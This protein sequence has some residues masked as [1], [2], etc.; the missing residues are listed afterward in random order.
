MRYRVISL[1]TRTGSGATLSSVTPS[2]RRWPIQSSWEGNAETSRAGERVTSAILQGNN[3]ASGLNTHALF[4]DAT[5]VRTKLPT[6]ERNRKGWAIGLLEPQRGTLIPPV[7]GQ[8]GVGHQLVGGEA[9]RLLSREDRGDNVRGEKS[10]SNKARCIGRRDLLLM[11]D[12]L[13]RWTVRLEHSLGDL[14]T[15]HE[16]SDQGRIRWRG[17]RDA[18]DDELHLLAGPLQARGNAEPDQGFFRAVGARAR[19]PMPFDNPLAGAVVQKPTDQPRQADL[20][21]DAIRTNLRPDEDGAR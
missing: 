19:R 13:D 9:G 12:V 10:Q 2:A 14:L 1:A 21:V 11:R 8:T 4:A 5:G 6:Q 3:R 20:K 16:Q 17:I 15:A 7:E 18:I